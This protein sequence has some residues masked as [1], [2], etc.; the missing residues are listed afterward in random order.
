MAK[1]VILRVQKNY[2]Q[3]VPSPRCKSLS[4]THLF[5]NKITFLLH[6]KKTFY[7][8]KQDCKIDTKQ[9]PISFV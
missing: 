2:D 4:Q 8:L 5:K 7:N 1:E 6:L 3:V 9:V